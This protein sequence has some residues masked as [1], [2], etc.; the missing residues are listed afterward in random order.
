MSARVPGPPRPV[1]PQVGI[2][3]VPMALCS[4]GMYGGQLIVVEG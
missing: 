4:V 2:I 3:V 1:A